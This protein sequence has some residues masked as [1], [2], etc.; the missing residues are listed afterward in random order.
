[1][2]AR[3]T[4]DLPCPW[5]PLQSIPA[6]ASRRFPDR[7]ERGVHCGAKP[8]SYSP[9]STAFPVPERT[10]EGVQTE[11]PSS[12]GASPLE[13]KPDARRGDECLRRTSAEATVRRDAKSRMTTQSE[14]RRSELHLPWPE[15]GRVLPR[16][17]VRDRSHE[18]SAEAT[19][20]ETL[21]KPNGP[22]GYHRGEDERSDSP[23]RV[24]ARTV[25]W[26]LP[27]TRD[28]PKRFTSARHAAGI[29]RQLPWGSVP[30]GV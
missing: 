23:K 15:P 27:P 7:Q 19:L 6:A 21:G 3:R 30:L 5:V 4:L 16:R 28:P 9:R 25:T 29:R 14:H 8:P 1:M 17:G 12:S 18:R 10:P 26:W 22:R 11:S 24:V 13:T 20:S 2:Q